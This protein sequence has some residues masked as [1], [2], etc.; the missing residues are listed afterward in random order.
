MLTNAVQPVHPSPEGFVPQSNLLST[1]PEPPSLTILPFSIAPVSVV[2]VAGLVS[3]VGALTALTASGVPPNI[4]VIVKH[5]NASLL[6]LLAFVPFFS[7][8]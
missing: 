8:Q 6:I 2:E 3:M 1:I 4:A 5:N 7:T